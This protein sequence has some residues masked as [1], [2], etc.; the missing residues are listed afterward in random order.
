MALIPLAPF[1]LKLNFPF[2]NLIVPLVC[3]ASSADFE[4]L[5]LYIP[6]LKI[7]SFLKY[8]PPIPEFPEILIVPSLTINEEPSSP[9]IPHFCLGFRFKIPC[10]DI[11][12]LFPVCKKIT[13]SRSFLYFTEV[14]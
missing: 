8:I 12:K 13:P 1:K 6:L 2:I 5:K 10:P 7:I 4:Q 11:F 3:K 9:S 14:S